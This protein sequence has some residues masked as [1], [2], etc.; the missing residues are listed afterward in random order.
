MNQPKLPYWDQLPDLDLYLDQVLL[1]V[2]QL[3]LNNDESSD[4]GLTSSMINNYV[5]HHHIEKPIKKKYRKSQVAR[6]IAI[7]CLKNVF[8]IQ[9]IGET[10]TLLGQEFRSEDLY[11]GFVSCINQE[12]HQTELPA[13]VA[14]ACQTLIQYYNTK[15]L[16]TE[17]KGAKQDEAKL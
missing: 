3:S 11:N 12:D 17:Y 15:A 9:E 7:T 8:S 2:N 1:L 14:S 6:L 13:I 4:K 10:L 5:K 16:I